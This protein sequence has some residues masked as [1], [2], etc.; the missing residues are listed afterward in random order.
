MQFR[1][2]LTPIQP[3]TKELLCA[4]QTLIQ[5]CTQ[6]LQ[7]YQ[8]KDLGLSKIRQKAKPAFQC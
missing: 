2:I 4:G 5:P 7:L 8:P 1:K 6:P 3:R